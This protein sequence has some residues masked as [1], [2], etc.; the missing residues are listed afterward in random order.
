MRRWKG[1]DTDLAVSDPRFAKTHPSSLLYREVS[2]SSLITITP[3]ETYASTV[4]RAKATIRI[5]NGGAGYTGILRTLAEA[6]LA[7][8]APSD[9][10]LNITWISNHSRHSLVALLGDIVDIAMTYEPDN[11]DLAIREGWARRVG[12]V[13]NDHF[14]I[15]GPLADPAGLAPS[16]SNKPGDIML[17]AA[18]QRLAHA[19]HAG[20]AI[21]H[22]RGDGSA[23][24]TKERELFAA[25]DVAS[26][27]S[28]V[29]WVHT[30]TLT[31]YAALQRANT[32]GAYL[33]TDRATFLT[34][35]QHDTIGGLRVFIEG[36][37]QLLN[38]CAAMVRTDASVETIRLAA[39]LCGD[40]ARGVVKDYGKDWAWRK[41]LFT[42]PGQDDFTSEEKL[43]GVRTVSAMAKL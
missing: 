7:H 11:E 33:L 10:Q 43:A 38:P 16:Q 34:A 14:V 22:S 27:M 37:Q 21:W 12:R 8:R 39:W 18:L 6:Y 23:T 30:H 2:A 31:P 24:F 17:I 13:F 32:D 5:G 28:N 20:K 4:A 40:E 42:V 3:L 26:A 9:D 35:Q 1:A 36:G 29:D 19:G 41:A 25:A 15:A